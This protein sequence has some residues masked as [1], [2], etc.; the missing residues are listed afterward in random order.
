MIRQEEEKMIEC[1]WCGS[2]TIE[3]NG[4]TWDTV[5]KECHADAMDEAHEAMEAAA[6]EGLEVSE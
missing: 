3:I 1:V 2:E 5:C 4:D 6:T